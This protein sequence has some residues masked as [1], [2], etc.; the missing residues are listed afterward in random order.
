MIESKVKKP[1]KNTFHQKLSSWYEANKRNLPFRET[2]IN[3]YFIWVSEIILQ[4]T[5]LEQ[6][7]PY[8][9]KF[10]NKYPD[11]Q[12]LST[13][14]EQDILLL[15]QGLG[16]YSRA[17]N[18][19]HTARY[20]QI[21]LKGEFPNTY[22]EILKL[23]GIGPYTAAA[24]SSIAFNEPVIALDGNVYRFLSRYFAVEESI[25]EAIGKKIIQEKGQK[26]MPKLNP[27]DFNQALIEI[28]ALICKPNNPLCTEC[29]VSRTC[30]AFNQNLTGILPI[31]K[32]KNKAKTK[33]FY[34][35]IVYNK[36]EQIIIRKREGAGIWKNM[37]EFPLLESEKRIALKNIPQSDFFQNLF[38]KSQPVIR[39]IS[40]EHKHILSHQILKTRFIEIDVSKHS[41]EEKDYLKIN[42]EEIE[43]YP[44]P[45]LIHKFFQQKELAL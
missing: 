21:K 8:Y 31:R 11:L 12:A 37:F 36:K 34:Y 29:P 9:L 33:Y 28:G 26:L 38:K 19:H 42:H 22:R 18:M 39:T 3:P 40:N 1:I 25:D 45:R 15:W 10:I 30:K 16:Y 2:P 41:Y 44:M 32:K 4:Q 5:R 14:N 6:G 24:I 7:L 20:I 27:G 43:Q 13:A 35:F 23:K 17:R